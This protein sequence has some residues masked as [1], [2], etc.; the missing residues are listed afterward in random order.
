MVKNIKYERVSPLQL[1]IEGL[2]LV[3]QV[4][5]CKALWDKSG[6]IWSSVAYSGPVFVILSTYDRLGPYFSLYYP[7]WAILAL[8]VKSDHI[9]IKVPGKRESSQ[10]WPIII[11]KVLPQRGMTNFGH[12]WSS[13]ANSDQFSTSAPVKATYDL[14]RQLVADTVLYG[15]YWS[16]MTCCRQWWPT[17]VKNIWFE[18]VSTR[19]VRIEGPRSSITGYGMLG[20]LRQYCP[21]LM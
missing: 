7:S 3:Y 9:K 14:W 16:R 10:K 17:I 15:I 4:M 13:I 20:S 2:G 12:I 18:R 5:E 19:Q 6:R 8:S 1:R 21:N 11:Q